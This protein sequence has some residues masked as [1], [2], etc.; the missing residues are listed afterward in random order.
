MWEVGM[1]LAV[2][3]TENMLNIP[4]G[5]GEEVHMLFITSVFSPEMR[6]NVAI[7]KFYYYYYHY[8]CK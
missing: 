1:P 6:I 4:R 2:R 5:W 8:Y 3:K 7:R